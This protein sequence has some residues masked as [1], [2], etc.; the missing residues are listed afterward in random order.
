MKMT[1]GASLARA[2]NTGV[3]NMFKRINA[4][5]FIGASNLRPTVFR[6]IELSFVELIQVKTPSRNNQNGKSG[7]DQQSF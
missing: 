2:E 5:I 1:I 7:K 4:K 3:F 6:Q